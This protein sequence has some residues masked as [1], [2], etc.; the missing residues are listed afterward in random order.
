MSGQDLMQ[1]L[2][3]KLQLLDRAINS[4]AKNG[5][6]FAEAEMEYKIAL[7]DFMLQKRTEGMP[8]TILGDIA[9]GDRK[10]AKLRFERDTAEAVYQANQEAIQAWK[11]Q[12]RITENQ[13]DREWGRRE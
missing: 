7:A 1:D 11:L 6:L 2:Q 8:V 3:N 13:I 10:I 9:R 4:L 12:I 5:R